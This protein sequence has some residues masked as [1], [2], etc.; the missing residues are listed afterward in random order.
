MSARA[1]GNRREWLVVLGRAIRTPRGAIGISIAGLVVVIAVLGPVLAP[2]PPLSS[3]TTPF[4]VPSPE[5]LLGGDLLGRDV[6]SRV[7]HGG[8]QLLVIAAGATLLGVSTG[9]ALGIAAGY[10]GGLSDGII[11]RLVDVFLAFPQLVFV[12]LL[13]SVAGSHVW[14]IMIAVAI[15]TAPPVARVIRSVALDVSERE[16]VKAAELI[17]LPP[18]KIMFFEILPNL[19]S[20]VMVEVGLRFTYAMLI[21]A[22]LSFLGFGTQAPEASW[23]LM[24][25]ENR[26]GLVLNAWPVVVP[27][28]LIAVLTIGLNTFTDAIARSSL[29]VDRGVDQAGMLPGASIERSP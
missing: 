15:A 8:W 20:V 5:F 19:F 7:L 16:F 17:D 6:L 27:A 23:G 13:V 24:I 3:V 1:M 12:M 29:G 21:I 11:M 10:R 25:N 2:H 28:L 9:V 4:A 14:L 26:I 18:R 22:G